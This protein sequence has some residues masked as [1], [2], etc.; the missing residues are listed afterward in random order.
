MTTTVPLYSYCFWRYEYFY[1]PK[2]EP[3]NNFLFVTCNAS[4]SYNNHH[5]AKQAMRLG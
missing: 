4:Q 3:E 1:P 2:E 5:G